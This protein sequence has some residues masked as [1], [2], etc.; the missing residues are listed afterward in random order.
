MKLASGGSQVI[1]L[2][3]LPEMGSM[4]LFGALPVDFLTDILQIESNTETVQ[5]FATEP[6]KGRPPEFVGQPIT[7]W[8]SVAA[9]DH[10]IGPR[11]E[12]TFV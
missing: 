10:K 3:L 6:R 4:L 1:R 9:I 8:A 12:R 7:L 5:K 11:H 2:G